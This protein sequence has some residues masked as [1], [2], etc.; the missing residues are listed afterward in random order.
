V[1]LQVR[2]G[3]FINSLQKIQTEGFT[4]ITDFVGVNDRQQVIRYSFA[5]KNGSI[6]Y[7]GRKIPSPLEFANWMRKRMKLTHLEGSIPNTRAV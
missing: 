2:A 4:G 7:A 1:I 5:F 6:T 3:E